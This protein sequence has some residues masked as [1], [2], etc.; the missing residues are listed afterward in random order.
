MVVYLDTSALVKLYVEEEEGRE[1][2]RRAVV[3]AD[4]VVTSTVAYTETRAALA[5]KQREGIFAEEQLRSAVSDL[6]RNWAEFLS[7]PVSNSV[8]R[9]AGEMAEQYAL[10]GFDAIHLASA[11]HLEERFDELRFLAFDD[12]LMD[13]AREASMAVYEEER[14]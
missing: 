5:R 7:L 14:S 3:E 13:A 4:R 10:R 9:L 6:D 1:L 2:V 11:K 12:R 8:A